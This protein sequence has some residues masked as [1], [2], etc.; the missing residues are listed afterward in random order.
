MSGSGDPGGVERGSLPPGAR[1]F[2]A[3]MDA[4]YACKR[5]AA[6]R[7]IPVPLE[8]FILECGRLSPS[9]FGL[10]HWEFVAARADSPDPATGR[11]LQERSGLRERLGEA[12]FSQEAVLTAALFVAVL[13]R[14]AAD[15][16][17]GSDFIRARA[18]RFPGG[19]PVFLADYRGY[20][21]H[22]AAGGLVE[23][24]AR[25]QAYIACANMM[26][27]AAAAGVDSCAIEGYDEGKLL[28][29]LGVEARARRAGLAVVFGYRDEER[30]ERIREDFASVVSRR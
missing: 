19:Y 21:E 6:D 14:P 23:H 29:A 20:Y 27:G 5:F 28:S 9:S 18:S 4:R 11:G 25:A 24:W 3:A 30:R 15:Y 22:L 12:C 10:E 8:D 2:L 7:L 17:P 13:V 1:A 26:T 16:E